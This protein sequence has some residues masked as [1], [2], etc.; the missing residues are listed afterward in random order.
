VRRFR[1]AAVSRFYGRLPI[2]LLSASA[3]GR[4][5]LLPLAFALSFA[6]RR[7]LPASTRH[8]GSS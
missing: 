8:E 1:C 4:L 6:E 2:P 7:A 3:L 5:L